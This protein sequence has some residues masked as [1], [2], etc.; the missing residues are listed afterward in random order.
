VNSEQRY[1]GFKPVS[2]EYVHDLMRESVAKP[3]GYS[4]KYKSTNTFTK[5]QKM[6]QRFNLQFTNNKDI[7]NNTE[8]E[9]E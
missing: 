4:V 6:K 8:E 2:S 1:L 7:F 3:K 9:S 5:I